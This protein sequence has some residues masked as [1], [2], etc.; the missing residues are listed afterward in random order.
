[1]QQKFTISKGKYTHS[2]K[3]LSLGKFFKYVL[4]N[5]LKEKIARIEQLRV[6]V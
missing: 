4:L 6:R 3:K 1:M 2:E 5:E